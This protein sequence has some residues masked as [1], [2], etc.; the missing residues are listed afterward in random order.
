VQKVTPVSMARDGRNVFRVE[1]QLETGS[2][3]RLRPG[4]EGVAKV[5]VENR[6]LAW[7]WSREIVNWVRLKLWAWTP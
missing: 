4:M 2:D 1:A 5:T 6:R 3:P 7:I